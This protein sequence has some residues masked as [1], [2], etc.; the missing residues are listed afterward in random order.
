VEETCIALRMA[1]AVS[2]W[3]KPK[4]SACQQK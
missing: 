2:S 3:L 4:I 1:L